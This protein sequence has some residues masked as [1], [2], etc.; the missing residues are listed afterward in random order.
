[1][2][3]TVEGAEALS[4]ALSAA[5]DLVVV[6]FFATW[7]GPCQAIAPVVESLAREFKTV[8]FVKVDVDRN[9]VRTAPSVL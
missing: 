3:K 7:C 9:R 6:D 4:R 5:R 1:M 2:A 8:D